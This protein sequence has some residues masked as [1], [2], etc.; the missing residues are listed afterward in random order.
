MTLLIRTAPLFVLVAGARR[1]ESPDQL[2]PS[3]VFA[4]NPAGG[5][6]TTTRAGLSSLPLS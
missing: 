4:S 3:P 5:F 1:R 2:D 6:E